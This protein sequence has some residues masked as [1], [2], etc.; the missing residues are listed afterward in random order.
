MKKI[1]SL[2]VASAIFMFPFATYAAVNITLREADTGTVAIGIDTETDTLET[3][4]LPISYSEGV[5]ITDVTEGDVSCSELSYTESQE[6]SNAILVTCNLDSATALDGVLANIA[7]TSTGDTPATFEVV[8]SDELDLDT[9]SLG[10]TVSLEQTSAGSETQEV[11]TT[12]EELPTTTETPTTNEDLMVTTGEPTTTESDGSLLSSITEYLPYVL[13]AGSVILLISIVVIILGKKKGPKQPKQ[14]K[15]KK[16]DPKQMSPVMG[17]EQKSERSLKDMVNNPDSA[18]APGTPVQQPPAQQPAPAPIPM[19][20]NAPQTP[21]PAPRPTTQQ[22]TPPISNASQEEDLQEILQRE[23]SVP[24]AMGD[25]TAQE[26][27]QTPPAQQ[28]SQGVPFST[29][30]ATPQQEGPANIMPEAPQQPEI[31]ATNSMQQSGVP[32]NAQE[33]INGQINQING[34]VIPTQQAPMDTVPP[35]QAQ[36][37]SQPQMP[38]ITLQ[39]NPNTDNTP[40]EMPPVPPTM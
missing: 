39:Q 36:S 22:S 40:E 16:G 38:P 29:G 21:P 26:I 15:G 6:T 13:I 14:Q 12:G 23:A 1:Y 8:E 5:E 28:P 2:L 17:G 18:P 24:T 25:N 11:T 7:F 10:Q 31:E 9:L 33:S 4:T 35:Q 30:F 3:V 19:S 32:Q 34:G 27:P 20:Q 37:E